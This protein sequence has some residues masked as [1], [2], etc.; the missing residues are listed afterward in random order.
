MID[1]L[2]IAALLLAV[3]LSGCGEP[4]EFADWTIP[5]PEGTPILEYA[6][7]GLDERDPAAIR[8]VEDLVF[9]SDINDPD[10]AA[11]QPTDVVA[12]D[13]GTVFI[14]DWG[15]KRIQMFDRD[16]RHLKT[17]GKA[18]QG[19]G[20][21]SSLSGMTIAGDLLIVQDRSNGRFSTWTLDGDHVGE[22]QRA[23]RTWLRPMYGLQDHSFIAQARTQDLEGGRLV[24][25]RYGVDGAELAQLEEV[26]LPP[27]TIPDASW[28]PEQMGQAV[29]GLFDDPVRDV[30]VGNGGV[31]YVTPAHEYQVL[32]MSLSAGSKWALRVAWRRPAISAGVRAEVAWRARSKEDPYPSEDLDW[33]AGYH[34]IG[35]LLTDGIGRL[36][37]MLNVHFEGEPPDQ[38]P[39]DVY[40]PDGELIASGFLPVRWRDPPASFSSP[41]IS[42]AGEYVYGLSEDGQGES[43]V[44]R[45]RLLLPGAEE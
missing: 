45:Y 16:G 28:T 44:T 5:V 8:L 25:G 9:G 41:W 39:T 13:D 33:P 26:D 30:A 7:V 22:H 20:E 31:V 12:T 21:F 42:A 34:A 10:A 23:S 17:L 43:V 15:L 2:I 3:A 24:I 27:A 14:A 38:I 1:R 35:D 40:S 29:I 36:F 37:V 32:A 11:F 18:G 19:P 4:L 6:P